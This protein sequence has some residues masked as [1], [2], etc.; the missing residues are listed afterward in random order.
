MNDHQMRIYPSYFLADTLGMSALEVGA[1][2]AL[3]VAYWRDGRLP[4]DER[5]MARIAK[6][7]WRQWSSVSKIILSMFYEDRWGEIPARRA[8]GAY[9]SRS[10][11]AIPEAV[12]SAVLERDGEVCVYCGNSDGP[13]HFDHVFPW[14]RGGEHTVDNLVISCAPCNLEKGARHPDEW[15]Q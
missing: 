10:R 15:Q 9:E 4:D 2:F 3:L 14:S 12:K 7:S 11:P 6:L 8:L 13:F 1:Y 5:H